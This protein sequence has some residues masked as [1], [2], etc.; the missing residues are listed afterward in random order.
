MTTRISLRRMSLGCACGLLLALWAAP[1]AAQEVEWRQ[2]YVKARQEAVEKNR[3]L[4]IDVGTENCFCCK[5][6]DLRTFNDPAVIALLNERCI[7]L[8][9]DAQ[10]HAR[11]VERCACRT[12]RPWSSPTPRARSSATRKASSRRRL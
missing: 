11:L 5:Q 7:P 8:K 6:L 1:A 9:I 10:Q 2:D 4:V 12:T 3:P